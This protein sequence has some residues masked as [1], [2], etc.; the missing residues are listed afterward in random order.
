M[1]EK[2]DER[3]VDQ[4][5]DAREDP[6]WVRRDHFFASAVVSLV[7]LLTGGGYGVKSIT[8]N[9]ETQGAA[10]TAQNAALTAKIEAQT[11]EITELR[12]TIAELRAARAE[13]EK[14]SARTDA[15]LNQLMQQVGELRQL[16]ASQTV[17]L[18]EHSRRLTSVEREKATK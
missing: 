10:L 1:T 5:R 18:A 8:T 3:Q 13:G 2:K 6:A 15:A 14:S 17:E 9:V 7:V 16:T 12:L 11:K 4:G